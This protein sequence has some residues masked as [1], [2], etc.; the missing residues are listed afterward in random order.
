MNIMTFLY[1]MYVY[2]ELYSAVQICIVHLCYTRVF[3]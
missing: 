2:K 1:N 3:N